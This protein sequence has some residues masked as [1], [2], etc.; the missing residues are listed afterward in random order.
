M[1]Q[2]LDSAPDV[3]A[4]CKNAGHEAVRI[5]YQ[6]HAGRLAHYTLDFLIMQDSGKYVML[7]TRGRVDIDVP[8]K[9]RAADALV[10][11]RLAQQPGVELSLR[12]R[13]GLCQDR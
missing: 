3:V 8:L 4:F 6:T 7:E 1:A 11:V 13:G 12:S 10:S 5:D 2:F 9:I